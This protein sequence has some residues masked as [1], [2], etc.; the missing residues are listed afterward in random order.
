M[1]P[2]INGAVLLKEIKVSKLHKHR[3]QADQDLKHN[4]KN[5]T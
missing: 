2:R 4:R 3:D 1:F 5:L